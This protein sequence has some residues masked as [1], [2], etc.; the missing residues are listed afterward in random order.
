MSPALYVLSK[1]SDHARKW[2]K[3][4]FPGRTYNVSFPSNATVH[5]VSLVKTAD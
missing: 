3:Q 1:G 4:G 5:A 2:F